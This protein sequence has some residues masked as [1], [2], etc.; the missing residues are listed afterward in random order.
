MGCSTRTYSKI[1]YCRSHFFKHMLSYKR[2]EVKGMSYFIYDSVMHALG[3]CFKLLRVTQHFIMMIWFLLMDTYVPTH[4]KLERF[5]DVLLIVLILIISHGSYEF[6]QLSVTT[7]RGNIYWQQ[8]IVMSF[9]FPIIISL[10]ET[11]TWKD[12]IHGKDIISLNVGL[13]CGSLYLQS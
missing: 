13:F 5:Y 3:H 6:S 10:Q 9:L 1:N 8:N 11:L 4:M 12:H 7:V 2:V